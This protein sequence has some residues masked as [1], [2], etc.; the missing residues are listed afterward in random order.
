[1]VLERKD[2]TQLSKHLDTKLLYILWLQKESQF[3]NSK[4]KRSNKQNALVALY[5]IDGTHHSK[6]FLRSSIQ[7]TPTMGIWNGAETNNQTWL[8]KFCILHHRRHLREAILHLHLLQMCHE[9]LLLMSWQILNFLHVERYV[10]RI[11]DGKCW[12]EPLCL[13]VSSACLGRSL[14]PQWWQHTHH[15]KN[16]RNDNQA[17]DVCPSAHGMHLAMRLNETHR[18]WSAIRTTADDHPRFHFASTLTDTNSK[19]LIKYSFVF[20]RQ[21]LISFKISN[22]QLPMLID[23]TSGVYV[24]DEARG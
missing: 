24:A 3:G 19:R 6:T 20:N 11:T 1:M 22:M 21:F 9:F 17:Y 8:Y 5:N 10:S 18:Y 13:L 16:W 14:Q 23:V 12:W 15:W 7:R 2:V 4:E